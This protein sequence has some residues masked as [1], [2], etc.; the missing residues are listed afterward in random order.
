MNGEDLE[1]ILSTGSNFAELL[2][3]KLA[4]FSSHAEPFYSARDY[5]NERES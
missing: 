2:K 1:V 3:A 4:M 5:L